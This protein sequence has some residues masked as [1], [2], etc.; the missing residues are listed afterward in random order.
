MIRF[1][2]VSKSYPGG[3]EG[4]SKVSFHLKRGE[5]AFLT[6]HSGA[7]KS[8][9]LKLIMGMERANAGELYVGGHNVR[10]LKA[11][12]I[13][14]FRRNIGFIFQDHQLLMDRSVAEN[15]ALPLLVTGYALSECAGR[16]R[17]ALEMVGL[18]RKE[19][20]LP[21]VLSSGEQQRVGL[22]RA[23]VN[24]PTLILADEPTGNLDPKLSSEVMHLFERFNQAGVTVLVAS[25]DLAL[26]AKMKHRILTL[27]NGQLLS[28]MHGDAQ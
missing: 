4:L 8:T 5:M 11:S 24:R 22:A 17:G 21:A 19:K 10:R 3:H 2:K 20:L 13:P 25:H 12:Q 9:L 28:N 26:V 15:V 14:H 1:D 7:G 6:G 18:L 23:I 27:E 16:V